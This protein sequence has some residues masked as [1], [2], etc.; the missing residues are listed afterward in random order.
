VKLVVDWGHHEFEGRVVDFANNP[1]AG[2]TVL[3]TWFQ[4]QHGLRSR[5]IRKATTDGNGLFRF[6][7]LSS[8]Q[9]ILRA[10][11]PGYQPAQV[12]QKIG[13]TGAPLQLRLVQQ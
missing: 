4:Q 1:I 13:I 11:A 10:E 3:L 6:T 2:A 12:E 9:R 8:G 5:S 7:Q